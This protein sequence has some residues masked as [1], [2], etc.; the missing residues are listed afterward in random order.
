MFIDRGPEEPVKKKRRKNLDTAGKDRQF[1]AF[2]FDYHHI[3]HLL[4]GADIPVN[5]IALYL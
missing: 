4:I 3:P 1:L 5:L 2:F